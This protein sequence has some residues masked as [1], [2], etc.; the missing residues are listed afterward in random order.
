MTASK[1]APVLTNSGLMNSVLKTLGIAAA[2][3]TL[4]ASVCLGVAGLVASGIA[5]PAPADAASRGARF[6]AVY[7]ISFSGLTFAKGEL[8]VDLD[9]SAYQARVGMRTSG[10]VG[11][12][13]P[14]KSNAESTGR[15][16]GTH[17]VPSK[18][19]MISKEADL[20]SKVS[21]DMGRGDVRDF[22]V[23]PQ[24]KERPDRI[25]VTQSHRRNVVDPLSAAL[26]PMAGGTGG[27]SPKACDRRIP[28]FDGW[29]RYDVQLSYRRTEEVSGRG[30]DGPVV[31]CG[32]RWIPVAGHRPDKRSVK[33]MA[34]NKHIEIWLAPVEDEP[35]LVPYRISLR[36]MSGDIV[37]E[38]RKLTR[39]DPERRQAAR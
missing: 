16:R 6:G 31:V 36:T 38:A 29:Q 32:A 17:V 15:L 27:L 37:V 8:S 35:L 39:L 22:A 3:T 13:V 18:Y 5:D 25:P 26:M 24:L 34:E 33:Y 9:G 2:R 30:Y 20:S 28:I 23:T 1:A 10:L 19:S 4:L 7:D 21:M 14:S 11:V 12:F